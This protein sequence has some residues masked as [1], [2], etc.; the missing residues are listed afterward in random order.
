MDKCPIHVNI[1]CELFNKERDVIHGREV[2]TQV[3]EAFF[4]PMDQ[5]IDSHKET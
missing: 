5:G 1:S 3:S 2:E 4:S